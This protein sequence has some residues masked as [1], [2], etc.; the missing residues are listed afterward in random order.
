MEKGNRLHLF[1]HPRKALANALEKYPDLTPFQR[2]MIRH[3]MF[4][5]T[6]CPPHTRAGWLVCF[7]DKVAAFGD[8]FGK[9]KKS[10]TPRAKEAEMSTVSALK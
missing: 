1:T 10:A 4:P 6:L 8:Y 7:Y 2:D 3:H 5:V 9:K